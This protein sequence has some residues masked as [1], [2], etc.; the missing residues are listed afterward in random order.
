MCS[1]LTSIQVV[2]GLVDKI[3][4]SS[5]ILIHSY[6]SF[7]SYL[8]HQ[9]VDDLYGSKTGAHLKPSLTAVR[10]FVLKVHIPIAPVFPVL[11]VGPVL[12]VA[13]IDP[14]LPLGRVYGPESRGTA[15]EYC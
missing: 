14:V 3:S 4:N 5:L 12:P 15:G 11:P 6:R 2:H 10:C 7:L 8:Y 1:C 9:I 13:P